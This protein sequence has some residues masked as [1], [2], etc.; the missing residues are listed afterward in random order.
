MRTPFNRYDAVEMG[1]APAS[2]AAGRALAVRIE[3]AKTSNRFVRSR[4]LLFG[5]RRAELQ[6]GRLCSPFPPTA[7]F[8]LL[9]GGAGNLP[10]SS[11]DPPDETTA[12]KQSFRP[13]VARRVSPFRPAGCR[14]GQAG[15]LCHPENNF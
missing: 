10:A 7:S 15:R 13:A 11:G 12:S 3:R 1:S 5:A 4:A 6:P 9:Q 14:T 8:R 2:G